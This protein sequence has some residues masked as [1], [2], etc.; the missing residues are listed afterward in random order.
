MT[1]TEHKKNLAW[2]Y[3]NHK[4]AEF[5]YYCKMHD[6]DI[7]HPVSL[8]LFR[9]HEEKKTV[10][11]K[12]TSSFWSRN[13]FFVCFYNKQG[14]CLKIFNQNKRLALEL[15]VRLKFRQD[16]ELYELKDGRLSQIA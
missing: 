16:A 8:K 5:E 6:L 13:G 7:N 14:E 3:I 9:N 1:L 10:E 15:Y 12:M 11:Q 2:L 4:T